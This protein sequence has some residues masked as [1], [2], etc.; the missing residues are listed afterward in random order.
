MKKYRL[1]NDGEILGNQPVIYKGKNYVTGNRYHGLI[2]LWEF[3]H[4]GRLLIR[5]L[6][7]I[8]RM[9]KNFTFVKA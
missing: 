6:R 3:T 1:D 9:R 4:K 7:H 8:V 5:K 2:E